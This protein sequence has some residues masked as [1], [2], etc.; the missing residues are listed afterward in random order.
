MTLE[1]ISEHRSFGGLQ[2]FYRHQSAVI[3]LPMQFSVYQPP[4]VQQ[5]SVPV[6]FY[7][8]GLT[9]TEETFM[10][11]A[12]A[13]RVAAELGLA[14]VTCDTSPRATRL[15]GDDE[16]WDF[17]LG[18][19]FYLDATEAP[20]SSA[21]RMHTYVVDELP[22]RVEFSS[23]VVDVVR[24]GST[25]TSV[26]GPGRVAQYAIPMMPMTIIGSA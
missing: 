25:A 15:P 19:G 16:G 14:L 13:Q 23:Y 9:C 22:D 2:G 21:Y 20:W 11:K 5:H 12:G 8:A 1:T 3:G 6:L 24:S 17:G 7:L 18:A 4:Q 26:R 10:I